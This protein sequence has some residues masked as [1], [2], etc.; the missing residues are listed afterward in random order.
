MVDI[1]SVSAL[2]IAVITAIG[3]VAKETNLKKLDC[4]FCIESDCRDENKNLDKQIENLNEKIKN[5]EIKINKNKN[6]LNI[7]NVKKRNNSLTAIIET[8]PSSP[9]SII[10]NKLNDIIETAI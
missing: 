4:C 8:P 10:S 1:V 3:T 7:A 6:K 2:I 5:N 9:T